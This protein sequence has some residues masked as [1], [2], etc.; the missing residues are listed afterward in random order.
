MCGNGYGSITLCIVLPKPR[1]FNLQ[2]NSLSLNNCFSTFPGLTSAV[3]AKAYSEFG[4]TSAVPTKTY[5]E[6]LQCKEKKTIINIKQI[7]L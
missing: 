4:L 3:S 6:L 5:S 2:K 7:F 1:K